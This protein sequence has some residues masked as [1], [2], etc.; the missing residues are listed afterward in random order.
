MRGPRPIPHSQPTLG[1]E[2]VRAVADVV[3]SGYLAEGAKTAALEAAVAKQAGVRHAAA[4]N[5]GSSALHLALLALGVG[6]GHE[7]VTPSYVC[8]ALLNAIHYVGATPVLADVDA[9]L[10]LCP[11]DCRRKLTR[12]TRAI[13]APHLLGNPAAMD[14]IVQ[15]GPPVIEDCAQSIGA[16]LPNG[17]PT[18]SHGAAAVFSFYATKMLAAGECGAVAAN[19]RRLIDKVADLKDYDERPTYK[20]RYNYKCNDLAAALTLCQLEKLPE[21]LR[22]RRAIAGL[23]AA[24]L[25]SRCRVLPSADTI[26]AASCFRFV[27]FVPRKANAII[28]H[29]QRQGIRARKPVFRPLHRYMQASGLAMSDWA[30]RSAVSL[31]IYPSLNTTDCRRVIRAT[32]AALD[33]ELGQ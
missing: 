3:R 32:H 9:S 16:I 8:T 20:V 10:N 22:R 7:V 12:R 27:L 28:A 17:S 15:F 14:D 1:R 13:I 31:P 23:Y 26:D 5:T 21:F 18:G 19:S 2:E 11:D 33:A 25:S 24:A 29:L 4:V 30:W 6:H